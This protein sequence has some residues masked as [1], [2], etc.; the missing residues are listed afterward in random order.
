MLALI[1]LLIEL[2]KIKTDKKPP[3]LSSVVLNKILV[4]AIPSILQQS[5]VSVGNLM[6]QGLVNSFD[7]PAIIAGYGVAVQLNTFAVTVFNTSGNAVSNFTAQNIGCGKIDRVRQGFR[8]AVKIG[9]AIALP[10][11]L[12]YTFLGTFMV[13]LFMDNSTPDALQT[14]RQFLMIVAPFYFTVMIKLSADGKKTVNANCLRC[15]ENT[16][17]NV[18]AQIG[19]DLDTG[20]DCMKCHSSIAH[21]ANHLEGGIKVE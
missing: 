20:A 11:T 16:M 10:F 12:V 1:A 9:I 4:L 15:H 17:K 21:G 19:V 2:K 5:F 13:G 3:L 8:S 6:I 7:S 14:G 18:H